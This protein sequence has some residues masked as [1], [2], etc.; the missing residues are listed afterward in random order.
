MKSILLYANEDEGQ[1]ARLQ[2]ALDLARA[3]DGRLACIQVTPYSDFV[4]VDSFGGA[5]AIPELIEE[6]NSRRE[7]CRERLE[8]RLR[9]EG[10]GWSW[11]EADGDAG[12]ALVD[13][14]RLADV[15]VLNLPGRDAGRDA[16]RLASDTIVHART[17]V[18][19][20]PAA[21][22]SF[23][24]FGPALVAWNGSPESCNA[25]RAALPMLK[26][27]S[28]VHLATVEEEASDFPATQGCEYL[29]LH[30][31]AA[32]LHALRP[33]RRDVAEVIADEAA[34]LGAA[35]VVMGGY[36]H[37]RF[38]EAVLGGTSRAMLRQDKVP[39]LMGH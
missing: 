24:S 4:V 21:S 35:Y 9:D 10:V 5:Y 2:T 32:E 33:E 23:D 29:S 39:L 11:I 30:G 36:G 26:L 7:A 28:A 37:S 17:P 19:A 15:I 25:L 20:A 8:A 31:V 18:L 38:R 12:Q 16:M 13:H 6:L 1:S 22:R 34:R 27:A 14:A 3:H